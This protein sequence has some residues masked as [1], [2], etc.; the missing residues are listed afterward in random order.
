MSIEELIKKGGEWLT[1]LGK[2]EKL[3]YL[4]KMHVIA[5]KVTW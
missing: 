5:K 1:V 4:V 2:K 3:Y